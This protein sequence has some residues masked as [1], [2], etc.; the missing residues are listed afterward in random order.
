MFRL[1]LNPNRQGKKSA[2]DLKETMSCYLYL[3]N[4]KIKKVINISKNKFIEFIHKN[5]RAKKFYELVDTSLE[6][7][8][9]L[10]TRIFDTSKGYIIKTGDVLIEY[11]K[12]FKRK[13]FN[14]ILSTKDKIIEKYGPVANKYYHSV[15]S[16]SSLIIR[17][18]LGYTKRKKDGFIKAMLPV[19]KAY[20]NGLISAVK[21][22]G[23]VLR[24]DLRK[25]PK[26]WVSVAQFTLPIAAIAILF[27]TI[28]YWSNL[29]Y[30]LA[31]AYDGQEIAT[32][33]DEKVVE[34]AS[35]M[36]NQR[37]V[38]DSVAS[39]NES[40]DIVPTYK[41]VSV[42]SDKYSS[43]ST[44]CDKIIQ[45]SKGA[46]EEGAGLY[47]SGELC[48]VLED[49]SK[50]QEVL[51]EVLSNEKADNEDAEVD[52]VEEVET[53]RGLFPASTVVSSENLKEKLN[54]PI[55]DEVYYTIQDGDTPLSIAEQFNMSLDDLNAINGTPVDELIFPDE[56]VKVKNEKTLL[57]VSVSK[58]EN[59]ET[60]IGY[61]EV[62]EEDDSQY[63]G[64]SNVIQ[65]GEEGVLACADKVT[66]VNGIETSR[67][68]FS[69]N[70]VKEPVDK[71]TTVGTKKREI[72]SGP[73]YKAP[74]GD[75]ISTGSLAWPLPGVS[76][77]SSPFGMRWGSM[78][79]GIDIANGNTYGQTIVAADGGTVTKAYDSGDGYGI[80][81][82]INH[83]N[84]MS[85]LYAHCSAAYVSAGQTVSKGQAIAA[86]G[87]TGYSDGAHL[88]FGVLSGGSYVNPMN[89][90]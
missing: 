70:T 64:Y 84:G 35:Q 51:D 30:G 88:H 36:V 57:N 76:T 78:H 38:Y 29:N 45:K 7:V 13:S 82:I 25:N 55:E 50:I 80:C 23:S 26:R 59:Y 18:I 75:G 71:K 47:I 61:Q 69:R 1:N 31:L 67:E 89:Y 53:V 79:S 16:K 6:N 66:Y 86:V 65:E 56:Q 12:K 2:Q 32:V 41:L 9:V 20:S 68:E 4:L 60:P 83:G 42:S 22:F 90:L 72:P 46:I 48:G 74:S 15:D 21:E 43:P 62:E 87:S 77:I 73:S 11:S 3:L 10:R 49:D 28:N 85:T 81:V 5:N 44:V 52:F 37:L 27:G 19:K 33:K 8:G 34:Q 40:L 54:T 17:K 14:L 63:V 24:N 39:S 58:I